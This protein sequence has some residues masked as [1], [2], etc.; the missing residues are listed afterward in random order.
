MALQ[1]RQDY[2]NQLMDQ[3]PRYALELRRQDKQHEQFQAMQNLREAAEARN[4]TLFDMAYDRQTYAS[5]VFKSQIEARAKLREDEVA[6]EAYTSEHGEI[7][8]QYKDNYVPYLS[9]NTY[10]KHLERIDKYVPETIFGKKLST[11]GLRD[12]SEYTKALTDLNTLKKDVNP[13][14]WVPKYI[15]PPDNL[16]IDPSLLNLV[17]GSMQPSRTSAINDA[18]SALGLGGHLTSPM[19]SLQEDYSRA[20]VSPSQPQGMQQLADQY[21]INPFERQ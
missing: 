14:D 17:V 5:K 7:Q 9:P 3:L 2:A 6:S 13:E 8:D 19:F 4:K 11:F 15:P 20:G 1:I 12:K 21:P 10:K 18:L 16:I